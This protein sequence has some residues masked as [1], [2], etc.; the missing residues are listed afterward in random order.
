MRIIIVSDI[1]ND[2]ENLLTFLD[3]VK[4]F[5]F[6]VIV[7]PGDFTDVN[8][9]KGFTQEDIVKVILEELKTLKKPILAVPGNVDTM[10]VLKI[11]EDEGV[12]IHGKG[13]VIGDFGF[14]GY[15]GAKT[16][17]NTNIEPSEE[18][19]KLGLE[20]GWKDVK[21]CKF[22][23][24]VTHNPPKNTRIDI[25]SSGI[26]V[27][28][29]VVRKFIEE[30]QPI[31]AISAHIHEARGIDKINNTFLMNSGRFPEG[32]FGLIDIRENGEVEGKIMNILSE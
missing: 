16:P 30:K 18:E 4:E 31:V 28:S 24:Q 22:K 7:C 26:H 1:H 6:D 20:N 21:D 32:Y 17:F 29:E 19:L 5:E 15:G 12:S 3:K 25:I 27:G 11:L 14:Y 2:T 9:P 23:I 10:G 13:R 8:T